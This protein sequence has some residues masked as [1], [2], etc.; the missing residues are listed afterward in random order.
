MALL[1]PCLSSVYA[2]L[3]ICFL[4]LPFTVNKFCSDSQ[5]RA[6]WVKSISSSTK[7]LANGEKRNYIIES[8]QKMISMGDYHQIAVFLHGSTGLVMS[9]R[10]ISHLYK[11]ISPRKR[12]AYGLHDFCNILKKKED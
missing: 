12:T 3:Q 11:I 2:Q 4:F 9:P 10:A 5:E 1:L 7:N 6:I 8:N